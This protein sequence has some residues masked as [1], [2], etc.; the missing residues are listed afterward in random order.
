[1]KQDD[2]E[3]RKPVGQCSQDGGLGLPT[4]VSIQTWTENKYCQCGQ[5]G[6]VPPDQGLVPLHQTV[7]LNDTSN[8]IIQI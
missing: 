7:N 2:D 1:M 3:T 8:Q 5:C 4:V 6:Q